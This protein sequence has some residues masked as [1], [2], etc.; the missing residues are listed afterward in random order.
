ML[1]ETVSWFVIRRSMILK[2]AGGQGVTLT[3]ELD[4]L[5]FCHLLHVAIVCIVFLMY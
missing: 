3:A 2:V 1:F 4:P 5:C